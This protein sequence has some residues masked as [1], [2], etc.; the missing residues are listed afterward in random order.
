MNSKPSSFKSTIVVL[1]IMALVL[2]GYFYWSGNSS[3]TQSSGTST[4]DASSDQAAVGVQVLNLLNQIQ[5]LRI[6]TSLFTDAGYRTLR[7][8]SVP[9]PSVDVG[10]PNPFAPLPGVSKPTQ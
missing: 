10:R 9:I 2:G 3:S 8:Y 4:L 6:D 7:D 5:S 1:I